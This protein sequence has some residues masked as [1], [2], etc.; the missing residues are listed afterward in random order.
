MDHELTVSLP[1]T[2]ISLNADPTRLA[3][4]IGNLLNN[5]CK[6][7]DTGGKISL[8][9]RKEDGEAVLRVKDSGIGIAPED[10]PHIFEMFRQAD[11]SLER[12][13][14]G[15]GIGLTLVKKIVELMGGTVEAHSEGLGRGSEFV[16]RLPV[17]ENAVQADRKTEGNG[18]RL[19]AGGRILVVDDNV[20]GA[21]SLALLLQFSGHETFLAHDGIEAVEAAERLRPDVILLDIGLPSLNGYE[22]CRRIRQQPWGKHIA[23]VAVTG[24]GQEEDRERS[25]NAGFDTHIVKPVDHDALMKLLSELLPT[26]NG[27]R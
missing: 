1:S 6:F 25:S 12:S 13:R 7:T 17:D 21:E 19:A 10:L 3:Q 16:I 9:L 27:D 26:G 8:S 20:D 5:A 18:T 11:K 23:L 4:A 14:G 2:P 24:W 15:L 22:A